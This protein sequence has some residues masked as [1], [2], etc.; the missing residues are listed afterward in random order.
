MQH[1]VKWKLEK[2]FMIW[3]GVAGGI[4]VILGSLFTYGTW[5]K[6]KDA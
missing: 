2:A 3:G 6:P 1:F 5:R 4:G